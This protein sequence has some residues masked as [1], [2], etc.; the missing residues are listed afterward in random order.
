MEDI[1]WTSHQCPGLFFQYPIPIPRHPQQAVSP[2]R[3]HVQNLEYY[4]WE[5]HSELAII[6]CPEK[7]GIKLLA[8]AY[9]FL[10]F[11]S[12]RGVVR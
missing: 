12:V 11:F 3:E 5:G 2:S 7:T 1:H 4:L 10:L 9:I 8:M 6:F